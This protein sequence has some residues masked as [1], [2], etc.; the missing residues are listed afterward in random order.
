MA[1]AEVNVQISLSIKSD[2]T[3]WTGHER[4]W[5]STFTS[6]PSLSFLLHEISSVQFSFHYLS[7]DKGF[8]VVPVLSL[9][10]PGINVNSGALQV[11]LCNVG[12]W[13]FDRPSS[14]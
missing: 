6:F 9:I 13:E 8:P 7:S 2:P 14:S 1:Y 5:E 12:P 11:S 4:E 3:M 10:F